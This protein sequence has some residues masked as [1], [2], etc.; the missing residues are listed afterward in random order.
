MVLNHLRGYVVDN[1]LP[2]NK[3]INA[4]KASIAREYDIKYEELLSIKE[5]CEELVTDIV[6]NIY[7]SN[8]NKVKYIN[9]LQEYLK[10]DDNIHRGSSDD[11]NVKK[12]SNKMNDNSLRKRKKI[13]IYFDMMGSIVPA[14]V[15]A[16]S[17]F[18]S[19]F[20]TSKIE[21][22]SFDIYSVV[23]VIL[24]VSTLP[25]IISWCID[26]LDYLIK[27]LKENRKL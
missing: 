3:I 19:S 8:D 4:V 23:V 26:I 14:I 27:H 20:E 11:S 21:L 24:F 12:N 9:M 15:A 6:N 25:M 2:D 18:F 1:G 16:I 22:D 7:V 17:V 13:S 10:Q 5:F